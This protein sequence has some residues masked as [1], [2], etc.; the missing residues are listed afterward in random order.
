MPSPP[1]PPGSPGSALTFAHEQ[2]WDKSQSGLLNAQTHKYYF[3]A[4]AVV[5]FYDIGVTFDEEVEHIW[6]QKW[7]F[8]TLL[9]FCLR[10][11]PPLMQ[12]VVLD[13]LF[14]PSWTAAVVCI[15]LVQCI[16]ALRTY[17]MFGGKHSVLVAF[18]LFIAGEVT[19][20]A[21]FISRTTILP[22][23]PGVTGCAGGGVFGSRGAVAFWA[24]SFIF[25]I[26]IFA[27]TI[28]QSYKTFKGSRCLGLIG[29]MLRDGSLYFCVIFCV[30]LANM[31]TLILAPLDLMTIHVNLTTILPVVMTTRLILSLKSSRAAST[32][33]HPRGSAYTGRCV[34][35]MTQSSLTSK[36]SVGNVVELVGSSQ[37]G[38]LAMP[39]L[40]IVV[41]SE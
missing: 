34:Q 32:D 20:M 18:A 33:F 40:D 22:D 19:F 11:V 25:D 6:K 7:G 1:G 35:T 4:C 27:M 10:Y 39:E 3:V 36:W 38:P 24:P 15:G 23:P 28:Y 31:M 37:L 14:D 17:A 8:S 2:M 9:W 26:V 21:F 29:I 5:L 12:I 16:F 41:P 30:N 13:A